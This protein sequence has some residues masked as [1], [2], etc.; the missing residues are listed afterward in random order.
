MVS[1]EEQ[2]SW[3]SS[4]LCIP[5]YLNQ[6]IVFDQLAT[7]QGGLSSVHE[8]K[9]TTYEAGS[10]ETQLT[11]SLKAGFLS[12]FGVSF[13]GGRGT[14][15]E[16]AQQQ[17]TSAQ[18]VYT[19]ASLF[20]QL[21]QALNENQLLYKVHTLEELDNLQSN[22]FVE[23]KALL[24]RNPIVATLEWLKN[25]Y[26]LGNALSGTGDQSVDRGKSRKQQD[27]QQLEQQ[28]REKQALDAMLQAVTQA[29]S[30]EIVGDIL[31]VKGA[32]AV[33]SAQI[34]YFNDQNALE[35]EDGE[36]YVVG[37]TIRVLKSTNNYD[38]SINLLRKTTLG[39]LDESNF[40][41]FADSITR[42][43]LSGFALPAFVKEVHPPAI[44]VIPIAIFT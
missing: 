17:E 6:Q 21:R 26:E 28:Q 37:K 15:A 2:S 13:G 35:I 3:E 22:Q 43:E 11:G 36:F 16:S 5:I 7:L 4:D 12:L 10:K 27:K 31:G 9:T 18:K 39:P 40:E 1:Y 38:Y 25:A 34:A 42:G 32:K 41:L 23:F 20:T 33:L 8:I 30:I 24:M 19:P 14:K 44:Q 29:G